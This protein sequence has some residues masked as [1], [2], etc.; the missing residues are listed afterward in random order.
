MVTLT[1]KPQ[2]TGIAGHIQPRFDFRWKY[3]EFGAI[4]TA[5][6]YDESFPCPLSNFVSGFLNHP[7]YKPLHAF[8]QCQETWAWGH[9]GDGR[10]S[11]LPP[12]DGEGYFLFEFWTSDYAGM[13]ECLLD[14]IDAL[15]ALNVPLKVTAP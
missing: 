15:T 3:S 6:G 14:L 7:K 13:R 5:E 4:P 11:D 12:K 2:G 1:Y 8:Y 9:G 10:Q